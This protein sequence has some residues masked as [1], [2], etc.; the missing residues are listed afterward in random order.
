MRAA[1]TTFD[2]RDVVTNLFTV[3]EWHRLGRAWLGRYGQDVSWETV[4]RH[5]A[6]RTGGALVMLSDDSLVVFTKRADGKVS[7]KTYK[8]GT[9]SWEKDLSA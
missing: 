1:H 2:R 5:Y 6:K 4:A 9:W 8:P 7:R 3:N